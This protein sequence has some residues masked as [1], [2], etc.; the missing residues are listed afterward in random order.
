MK[1]ENSD[2]KLSRFGIIFFH[3]LL[4]LLCILTGIFVFRMVPEE[5][6]TVEADIK[7]SEI[8]TDGES[9]N[10]FAFFVN[11]QNRDVFFII[12]IICI[13]VLI[14][15]TLILLYLTEQKYNKYVYLKHKENRLTKRF[16]D[17]KSLLRNK[18]SKTV[19]HTKSVYKDDQKVLNEKDYY[20]KN[21]AALDLYKAYSNSLSEL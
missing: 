8:K 16:E 9:T 11:E 6:N 14:A 19:T 20:T 3:I 4:V 17:T 13:T 1:K 10:I 7:T 18:K 2:I 21:K 15:I 5:F 12:F